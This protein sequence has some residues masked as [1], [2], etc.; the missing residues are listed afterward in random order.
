MKLAK[1]QLKQLIREE[2]QNTSKYSAG[3]WGMGSPSGKPYNI[4]WRSANNVMAIV[5]QLT[6]TPSGEQV[7]NILEKIEEWN[8]LVASAVEI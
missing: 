7:L 6:E 3:N 5:N 4:D 1:S 8:D 2:L